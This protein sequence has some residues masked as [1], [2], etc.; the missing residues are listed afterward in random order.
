MSCSC[1]SRRGC[2]CDDGLGYYWPLGALTPEQAADVAFP[3]SRVS[4]KAGF[5]QAVRDDIVQ[6][7]SS[8]AF[9]AFDASG[10]TNDPS[11]TVKLAQT[12]AGLALTG[13]TIGVSIAAEAATI[14]ALAPWTLGISALIGIFPIIFAHHAA[15]VAR[16]KQV[17]CAS[18]PAAN[19]TL[20]VIEAAVAGG[21]A[22]P[23][24]GIDALNSLLSDFTSKVSSIMKNNASQC[25][26]ACVWVKELTAIVAELVSQYQDL[27][28]AQQPPAPAPAPAVTPTRPNVTTT[29]LTTAA[30]P[31][32]SSYAAFG[33]SAAPAVA[34]PSTPSWLPIA[35]LGVGAFLLF[36]G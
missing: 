23:K 4:S 11:N 34:T 21:Q 6:A 29:N 18:V 22:T 26:A 31:I 17:I 1:Q 16:E 10:C 24:Q 27:Q 14:A 32:P 2:S 35:A 25:N 9:A 20:Q 13:V 8:G 36:R 28:A 33:T 30:A 12:A 15:A 7:A 19:N 3:Q 5:N